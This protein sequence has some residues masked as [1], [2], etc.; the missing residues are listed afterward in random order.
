LVQRIMPPGHA[1]GNARRLVLDSE[2][3][4]Q[5]HLCTND[6]SEG[7]CLL[8]AQPTRLD[9]AL[10]LAVRYQPRILAG[11]TDVMVGAGV[12]LQGPVLDITRIAEIRGIAVDADAVTIGAGIT[13]TELLHADLPSGFAG[14]K[15][16]AREVGSVQIQNRATIAGNLCNASPAA[17]GVPPLLTLDA[18]LELR[19]SYG[20]RSVALKDFITGN[21]RTRLESGELVTAIRIPRNLAEGRSS[22]VKLGSR[23]YLVISIVSAAALLHTDAAGEIDVARVAVG[24]CSP[25]PIRL[26]EVESMLVGHMLSDRLP[27]LFDANQLGALSPIN[28]VRATAAYRHDAALQVIRQAILECVVGGAGGMA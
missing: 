25:V 26:P 20:Q 18:E 21:R 2:L 22:F 11:G 14:L 17:D 28:D 27:G 13:W 10:D 24:A 12:D 19:S 5:D 6:P 1:R 23:R 15:A 16:A 3:Y 4:S 9:E 7:P 8:Y